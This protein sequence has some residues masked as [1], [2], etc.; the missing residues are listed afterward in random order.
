MTWKQRVLHLLY[1]TNNE[2]SCQEI[3]KTFINADKIS[4]NK[5]RYLSGSISSLLNK[6][7]KNNKVLYSEN[8]TSRGGYLYKFNYDTQS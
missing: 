3:T 5:A 8:K 4:G 6:L 7:V 1:S 2:M